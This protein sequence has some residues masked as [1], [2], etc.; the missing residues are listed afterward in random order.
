MSPAIDLQLQIPSAPKPR[1]LQP[2]Q[3]PSQNEPLF[4]DFS[5]IA[6]HREG[7][8]LRSHAWI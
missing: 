3:N 5:L 2:P 8:F 4:K 7:I 6:P 1:V